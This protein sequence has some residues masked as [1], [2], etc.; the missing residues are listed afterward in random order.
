MKVAGL[1]NTIGTFAKIIPLIIFVFILAYFLDFQQLGSDF[2]GNSTVNKSNDLGYLF[3]QIPSPFYVAL[4]CFIG[5]EGA[6]VLSGRA[7]N[8]KNIGKATFWGFIISLVICILISVLPFGVFTQHQLMY[9]SNTIYCW[10]IKI[11][12]WRLGRMDYKYWDINLY[13]IEL[14][15]LDN[16][17]CRNSYGCSCK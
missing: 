5:I 7:K 8:T 2:W 17:L 14:V 9:Y 15:S 4:W 13:I 16:Y 10:N 12:C 1:L 6:V 11:T 3:N